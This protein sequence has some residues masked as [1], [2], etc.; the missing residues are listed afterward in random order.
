MTHEGLFNLK[1]MDEDLATECKMGECLRMA[2][3]LTLSIQI[4]CYVK[5]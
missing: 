5:W 1:E 3:L 2:Y 4:D